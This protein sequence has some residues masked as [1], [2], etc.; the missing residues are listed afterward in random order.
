MSIA[1]GWSAEEIR[2]FVLAYERVRHGGKEQWLAEQGISYGRLRRWRL[3]V[4]DGD[5]DKALVP[6]EGVVMTSVPKR[7]RMAETAAGRDGEIERLQE[8]VRQLEE[9]NDVL[10]KA[11]GLL[12]A[13]NVHEPDETQPPKGRGSS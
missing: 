1:P 11:I 13:K 3:A 2:R 4:F 12:H 10:G 8:R 9:A 7:R 5:V 6:R